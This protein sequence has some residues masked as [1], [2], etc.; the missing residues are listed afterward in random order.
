VNR[1]PREIFD[2]FVG[3]VR[4]R[5]IDGFRLEVLP[6]LS[7]YTA[8]TAGGEGFVGYAQLPAG[9]EDAVIAEQVAHFARARQGFEWKVFAFDQPADLRLR[10][11]AHGFVAGPVEGFSVRPLAG[12]PVPVRLPAGH[13]I[14]ALTDGAG[15]RDFVAVQETVWERTFPGYQEELLLTLRAA[16]AATEFYGVYCG[17]RPVGCG[18]LDYLVGSP[19]AELHA[20]AVLPEF[21]RRGLYSALYHTRLNRA[22]ARGCRFLAVDAAPMSRPILAAKGFLPICDTW[23]MQAPAPG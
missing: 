13:A 23:P 16:P 11:E 6:H 5:P 2:L 8:T 4:S 9:Q 7:R 1:A 17:E 12:D 22:Q 19:F 20:G 18:K 15:I 10:L 14:R 3:H 21:R